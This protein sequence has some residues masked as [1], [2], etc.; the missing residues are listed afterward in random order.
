MQMTA[1]L[2][3]VLN[4][5]TLCLVE[6]LVSFYFWNTHKGTP[7]HVY[8]LACHHKTHRHMCQELIV[9]KIQ[10][11]SSLVYS[12]YDWYPILI[13]VIQEEINPFCSLVGLNP[14]LVCGLGKFKWKHQE[15]VTRGKWGWTLTVTILNFYFMSV[16]VTY[17]IEFWYLEMTVLTFVHSTSYLCS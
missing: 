7:T 8:I 13:I 11:Y 10:T 14:L 3:A 1:G 15:K 9:G 6:Q 4:E 17:C 12:G 5:M 16:L 2:L